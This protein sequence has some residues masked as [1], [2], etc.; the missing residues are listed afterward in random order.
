LRCPDHQQFTL[1]R[2]ERPTLPTN[3]QWML[4]GADIRIGNTPNERS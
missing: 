3:L 1:D 4:R 2:G